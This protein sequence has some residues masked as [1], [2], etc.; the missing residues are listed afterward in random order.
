MLLQFPYMLGFC[1]YLALIR[2]ILVFRL[3]AS[4]PESSDFCFSG[5]QKSPFT[6]KNAPYSGRFLIVD[7]SGSSRVYRLH[8][9]D[10][11]SLL[12][13]LGQEVAHAKYSFIPDMLS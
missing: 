4:P 13:S 10:N 12:F 3:L 7:I 1:N 6:P 5:P 9:T 11:V 2:Q 8:K